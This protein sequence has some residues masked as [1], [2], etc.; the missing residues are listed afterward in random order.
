MR[1]PFRT[2][3]SSAATLTPMQRVERIT[4]IAKAMADDAIARNPEIG[5]IA[6][7]PQLHQEI[8]ALS[9]MPDAQLDQ[10]LTMLD[11]GV[12]RKFRHML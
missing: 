9:G 11:A 8:E 2:T 4:R 1:N 7:N 3:K 5:K 10:F 12:P 6:S